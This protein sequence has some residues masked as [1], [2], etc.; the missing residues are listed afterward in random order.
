MGLKQRLE[1]DGVIRTLTFLP[2]LILSGALYAADVG[3]DIALIK[4]HFRNGDPLWGW[5]SFL[6]V[7]APWC[8]FLAY[9]I[10][11]TVGQNAGRK[12]PII[13]AVFNLYPVYEFAAVAR[14]Y[15]KGNVHQGG[16]GHE[17]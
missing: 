4:Q 2:S 10:L 1:S 11:S 17:G 5:F 9:A 14:D 6:L 16:S 12:I 3:S 7:L 8:I 13:F 15:L